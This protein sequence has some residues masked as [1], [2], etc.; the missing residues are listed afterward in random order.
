MNPAKE[1]NAFSEKNTEIFVGSVAG[2][3]NRTLLNL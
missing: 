2:P 1:I 3:P